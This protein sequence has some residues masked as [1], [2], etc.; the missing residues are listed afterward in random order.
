MKLCSFIITFFIGCI[1]TFSQNKSTIQKI[2][3]LNNV[4]YEK[5]IE[6]SSLNLNKYLQNLADSKK[7]NYA[8]GIADSNANISLIY[9]YRGEYDLSMTYFFNAIE[10]YKKINELGK[11]GALYGLYGYRLRNTDI[12]KAIEYMQ[13]GIKMAEK[14]NAEIELHALYDNYGL[15]KEANKEY[16]S[17][18]YYYNKS[19]KMK[20]K[21][22]DEVGIP[23][24]L[25]KLGALNSVLGNNKKAKEYFDKAYELR[26]KLGDKVGIAENLSF[27]GTYY[28]MQNDHENAIKYF[29][30]ALVVSKEAGYNWLTY[31]IY[32]ALANN[33]ESTAQYKS[34]LDY[35]RNY[36][37]YKDSIYN[38]ET[39]TNRNELEI[40]F[41]SE[42]KE[43]QILTQ[44]AEIAESKLSLERKNRWMF[45]IVGLAM[46]LGVIGYFIYRSQKLKNNQL[47][48]EN[49][50]KDALIKIETQ[51][52]IQE[53]RLR[54]SR[55]LHD[56]IGSQLTFIISSLDNLKFQLN[57][58]NPDYG[59]RLDSINQFT[60]STIT[61]LRD[62]IWAMNKNEINISDLEVRI[63]NYLENAKAASPDIQFSLHISPEISE[64]PHAFTS[65]EGINIY[66]VIQESVNN[67]IKHAKA[68]EIQLYFGKENGQFRIEIQDNGKGFDQT[69]YEPGNGMYNMNKRIADIGGQL[70]I[71]SKPN[72]GT[73]IK[74]N[75]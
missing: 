35:L 11:A 43:K 70:T 10:E 17:A 44:R 19:L 69:N 34:A 56:N 58:Q 25:N 67:A 72:E 57:K 64:N 14:A 68:S 6:T 5:R 45:G 39:T 13:K 51:N 29:Q 2:D 16:D 66:R 60:R 33:F 9:F 26:I 38:V 54:I 1:F 61:E 27:Y 20:Q 62:T 21:N 47:Q 74:I 65:F 8:N 31:K 75:F 73:H 41:E 12:P 28:E 59:K 52:K 40:Q 53:E 4:S 55:D 50:L 32:D 15:V 24:S 49:Q 30:Q 63:A 3:S 18:A 23:Y 46:I 42:E 37:T 7:A 71:F 36:T 22:K 48:K